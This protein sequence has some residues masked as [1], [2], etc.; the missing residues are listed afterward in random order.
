[1]NTWNCGSE[2][3]GFEAS[4]EDLRPILSGNR[5]PKL[6]SLGLRGSEITDDIA[7]ALKDA[8]ILKQ[9]EVLD[10]SL[11]TLGNEGAEA[12]VQNPH[13]KHLKLLDI[14]HHFVSDE[15]VEQLKSLGSEVDASEQLKDEEDGYR[16]VAVSE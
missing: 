4:V 6:K 11:G 10:L 13:I 5:F 9:L 7:K 14:H 8:P 3:Y 16:Y 1:M 12:L 2:S 15:L